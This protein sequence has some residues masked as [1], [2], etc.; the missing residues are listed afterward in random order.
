MKTL[1]IQRPRPS[2]EIWIPA[3][4]NAPVEV[5]AGELAIALVGVENFRLAVFRQRPPPA[6]RRKTEA[7][8]MFDSRHDSTARLAQS[9]NATR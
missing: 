2:I 9:I 4:N 8:I 1:S 6:P 7:S 5:H 3:S